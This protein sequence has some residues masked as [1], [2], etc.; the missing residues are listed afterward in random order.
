MHVRAREAQDGRG[1]APVP[2]G[3]PA[4]R[5]RTRAS[6]HF[7]VGRQRFFNPWTHTDRGVGDLLRWWWT[8]DR[9]PWPAW[10]ENRASVTPSAPGPGDAALTFVGHA[11]V[12]VRL[13]HTTVLTDP[14]FSP[15][16][17]PYGRIGA[18]AVRKPGIAAEQLPPID[19]VFVSHNHYDHLDLP[20]LRWLD[21]HRQPSFITCLGLKRCLE[22]NGIRGVT[23]LDWWDRVT[24]A[25]VELTL[26]PAQHW[27]NRTMFDRNATLW[28]GCHLRHEAGATVYFAG[29][30]GYAPCFAQVRE[31]LGAPGVALL[32]I[33]AYEPRWFMRD[34]HMNPDDAVRAH[35]DVGAR[36][37][38]ATH[39]GFFRLT[40]EGFDEP[41][42]DLA[43]ARAAHGISP[44]AFRV[45]DVGESV[46]LPADGRRGTGHDDVV[47]T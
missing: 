3:S 35:V 21:A 18:A 42:Q 39:F 11:S 33:G 37:S 6:D 23:E 30:T 9:R 4:E 32:P 12:L 19:V 38:M 31:R 29:D 28:G 13:G 24:I 46:V 8:A 40:D 5:W 36:T 2:D 10:V 22:A 43:R 26:T 25:E 17:G 1:A 20:T 15:H 47:T 16:A 14:Q 7:D 41:V 44:D 34:Y 45:V 27:S